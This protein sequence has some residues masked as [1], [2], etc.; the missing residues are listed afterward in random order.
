MTNIAI[1]ELTDHTVTN[2]PSH[3]LTVSLISLQCN[4]RSKILN[5]YENFRRR[6]LT[7]G[8]HN[9]LTSMDNNDLYVA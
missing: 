1:S 8:Q 9:G 3:S 4:Q 6:Q 5:M 2:E 7:S